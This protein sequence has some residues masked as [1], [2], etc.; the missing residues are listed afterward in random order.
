MAT[1]TLYVHPKNIRLTPSTSSIPELAPR[2]ERFA[3]RRW[4][5]KKASHSGLSIEPIAQDPPDLVGSGAVDLTTLPTAAQGIVFD[6]AEP[7]APHPDAGIFVV[8]ATRR[9][10]IASATI[11]IPRRGL[12]K[13]KP[14]AV[15]SQ[16]DD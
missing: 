1:R 12:P 10:V 16:Q 6:E 2:A 14:V 7:A 8:P 5:I 13:G 11:T 3:K 4:R 15:I 9:K